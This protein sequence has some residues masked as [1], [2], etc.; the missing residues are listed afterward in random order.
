MIIKNIR[1]TEENETLKL[2]ADCKIRK[3]GFDTIYFTFDK[4]FASFLYPDASPFAAALFIPCMKEGEDLIIH[5]S[6]SEKL[7]SG[8]QKIMDIMITWN[9]GLKKIRIIPDAIS[10]DEN[11]PHAIASFFSG[12]V[13]SFHTYL[14]NKH[15]SDEK[16]T[17]FILVNGYDIDLRNKKLWEATLQDVM[18]TADHEGI[19]VIAVESNIKRLNEPIIQWTQNFGG[20]LA[21]IGLALRKEI[22]TVYIASSFT[23]DRQ[24]PSGSHLATDFLWSTETIQFIHDGAECTRFEKIQNEIAT[25][26][27]AL[28]HLRVCY[29]NY[30]AKFNCGKCDKCLRTMIALKICGS[31]EKASTFPHQIS[32][33]LIHALSIEDEVT[34]SFH[35]ENLEQLQKLKI[36]EELQQVLIEKLRHK[37]H[38]HS[39]PETLARIIYIDHMYNRGRIFSMISD[40]KALFKYKK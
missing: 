7:Y 2:S 34:A 15:S 24:I 1:L 4:K 3:I 8:M 27:V 38:N 22:K 39:A 29:K 32:M 23:K 28:N 9:T 30:K 40:A 25:S 12:G 16:I 33:D 31:L 10:E 35:T 21:A 20:C 26:D 6:I 14:K 18:K 37:M 17:H 5:G 11:E 19:L 13:D 36:E